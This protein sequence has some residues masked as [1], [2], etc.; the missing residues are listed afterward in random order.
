MNQDKEWN[1]M[2]REGA[3]CKSNLDETGTFVKCVF[4]M[5]QA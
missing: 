1:R 3:Q 5:V 4:K 2:V